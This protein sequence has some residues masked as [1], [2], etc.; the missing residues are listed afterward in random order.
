VNHELEME[1]ARKLA[2]ELKLVI[3]FS[4]DSIEATAEDLKRWCTGAIV[5]NRVYPPEAQARW[6]VTEARETWDKWQGTAGLKQ[7]FDAKFAPP[8]RV[9]PEYAS[10]ERLPVDCSTCH[11]T[12]ILL[13]NGRHQY[14]DCEHGTRMEIDPALGD[15]W[16]KLM[17]RSMVRRPAESRRAKREHLTM[18]ELEARYFAE[19]GPKTEE[20]D[21]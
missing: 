15:E 9:Y 16:L 1:E 20:H 18:E 12:G 17:D 13:V 2:A 5:A 8:K 10:P 11:D 6:L 4:W 3:G 19:R 21:G 7:L 14:C